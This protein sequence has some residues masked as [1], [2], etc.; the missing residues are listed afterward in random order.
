MN[1][2]LYKFLAAAMLVG[3]LSACSEKEDNE[4]A[5]ADE[6]Q[7]VGFNVADPGTRTERTDQGENKYQIKWSDNE[8]DKVRVYYPEGY[9]SLTQYD[10]TVV[11]A[12]DAE[13]K[14]TGKWRLQYD[15]N[16]LKWGEG[17]THRFYS[18][19]PT[20]AATSCTDAGI[21]TFKMNTDQICTV[22]ENLTTTSGTTS[23]YIA[24]PDMT[25]SYLV[26]S[27]TTTKLGGNV[28]LDYKPIMTTLDVTV[29]NAHDENEKSI[30]VSGISIIDEYAQTTDATNG[31]FKYNAVTQTIDDSSKPTEVKGS[32][33]T[34]Y[35]RIKNGDNTH[36]D[37]NPG[38]SIRL[39]VFLPPYAVSA[40]H[41]V[42]IKVH[43]DGTAAYSVE[44][45]GTGSGKGKDVK[46]D[47]SSLRNLTIKTKHG[48]TQLWQTYLDDNI[49]VQQLSIPGSNESMTAEIDQITQTASLEDQLKMGVRAFVFNTGRTGSIFNPGEAYLY[50][51]ENNKGPA[52]S[53]ALTTIKTFLTNNPG[54]FVFIIMKREFTTTGSNSWSSNFKSD[55][56]TPLEVNNTALSPASPFIIS[57]KNDLTVGECRG[58]VIAFTR[59][60]PSS[61]DKTAVLS[62]YP[63]ASGTITITPKS[64]ISTTCYIYCRDSGY[65]DNQTTANGK[66][67]NIKDLWEQHSMYASDATNEYFK[68]K[69]WSINYIGRAVSSDN[70][71]GYIKNAQYV[72][73][74]I[75]NYLTTRTTYGSLGIVLVDFVGARDVDASNKGVYG[76]L[77]TQAILDFN[78]RY[79]M[80][81]K[82]N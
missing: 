73:L 1:K 77:L 71:A 26:A 32:K 15:A 80:L 6:G 59:D 33:V 60:E 13:N 38:E 8:D 61:Y 64:G 72:N 19:Y 56:E 51:G 37:L 12:K 9:E 58:H 47:A 24:T 53:T 14:E 66:I 55:V 20:T 23:S 48:N 35:V 79:T 7:A 68:N 2:N 65:D 43:A 41:P 67:Q 81:R 30:A 74:A 28:N 17:D 69:N 11:K 76:D 22:D 75:Y 49:Y 50:H 21:I 39:T 42:T 5:G 70:K 31:Q 16:G 44:L 4:N 29:T 57:W 46:C 27:N 34:T 10:Y 3:G 54:E 45:G 36:I 62:S 63:T 18:V 82:S 25:N 78:Y 52:L 40:S